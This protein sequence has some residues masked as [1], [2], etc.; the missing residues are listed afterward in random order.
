MKVM[1]HNI[2][3]STDKEFIRSL[4]AKYGKDNVWVE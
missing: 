1:A 4:R 3:I 2:K